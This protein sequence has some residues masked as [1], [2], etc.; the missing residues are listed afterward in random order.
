MNTTVVSLPKTSVART[1]MVRV[2]GLWGTRKLAL[3][4]IAGASSPRSACHT[5]RNVQPS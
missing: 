3:F 2:P 1:A 4:A 5:E